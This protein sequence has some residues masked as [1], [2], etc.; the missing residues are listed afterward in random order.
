MIREVGERGKGALAASRAVRAGDLLTSCG[1]GCGAGRGLD[2]TELTQQW[3]R[4]LWDSLP[5]AAFFG[6]A[7]QGVNL[8]VRSFWGCLRRVSARHQNRPLQHQQ[9]LP[10]T[11]GQL[12]ERL[13]PGETGAPVADPL[14]PLLGPLGARRPAPDFGKSVERPPGCASSTSQSFIELPP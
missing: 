12:V 3:I 14:C 2:Q 13:Q 6:T 11:A 8:A 10:V 4:T 1:G 7:R 9:V 5:G